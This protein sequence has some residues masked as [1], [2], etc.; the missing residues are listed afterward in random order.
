MERSKA[1]LTALLIT[2]NEIF[3]IDAV[4]DNIAFAD[5][6]IVIDSNSTDGTTEKIRARP[7]VKLI[8]R[9]FVNFTDQK[10][11]ALKQASHE[12]VLFLDADERV[13]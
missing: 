13:T 11:F 7:D 5:E 3:H 2:Y 8:Q 4:L 12:W 10:S 1:K 6:V 9:P